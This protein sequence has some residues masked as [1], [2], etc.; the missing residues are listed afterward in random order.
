MK[1]E[2]VELLV[3]WLDENRDHRLN[4]I[5]KEAVKMALKKAQTVGDLVETALKLLKNNG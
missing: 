1:Q 5:E 3:K 2:D 4:L